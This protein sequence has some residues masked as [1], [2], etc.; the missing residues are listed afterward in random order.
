MPKA[1]VETVN[2]TARTVHFK[3]ESQ[4]AACVDM[5]KNSD[6]FAVHLT[7]FIKPRCLQSGAL[8]ACYRGDDTRDDSRR[9][10]LAQH[11]ITIGCNIVPILQRCVPL[12]S[13]L[14]IVPCN[15]T[16]KYIFS[17]IIW[18]NKMKQEP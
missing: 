13:S 1:R 10:F 5:G 9:R 8:S 2:E 14:Q 17:F 7:S 18:P 11:S 12:K 3:R 4:P 16:L 15:I 6:L